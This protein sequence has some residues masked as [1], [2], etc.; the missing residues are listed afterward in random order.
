LGGRDADDEAAR[1]NQSVVGP[2]YGRPKPSDVS[3]PMEFAIRHQNTW[4]YR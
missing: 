4:V 2:E 1:R 3:K